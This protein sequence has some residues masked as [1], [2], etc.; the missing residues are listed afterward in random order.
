MNSAMAINRPWNVWSASFTLPRTLRLSFTLGILFLSYADVL[1][2]VS[3]IGSSRKYCELFDRSPMEWFLSSTFSGETDVRAR[4]KLNCKKKM[5]DGKER[6]RIEKMR[7]SRTRVNRK[8]QKKVRNA[9][10]EAQMLESGDGGA[11]RCRKGQRVRLS[12]EGSALGNYFWP[13]KTPHTTLP[14]G[15]DSPRVAFVETIEA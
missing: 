9:F 2:F 4:M 5:K 7:G 12:S 6:A 15:L 1:G 3:I 13:V 11:C 10:T 14:L 8:S